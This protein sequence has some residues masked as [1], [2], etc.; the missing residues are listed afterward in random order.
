MFLPSNFLPTLWTNQLIE[1]PHPWIA[2]T[3]K[4][5]TQMEILNVLLRYPT[6]G[7]VASMLFSGRIEKLSEDMRANEKYSYDTIKRYA[8]PTYRY[9]LYW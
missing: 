6:L 4:A 3:L 1:E 5:F 9:M 7:K 2:I 8:D